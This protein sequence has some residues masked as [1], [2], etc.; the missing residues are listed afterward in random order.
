M[1]SFF[2]QTLINACA[3]KGSQAGTITSF[4]PENGREY[5]GREYKTRFSIMTENIIA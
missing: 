4:A 3:P 2:A 5:H 1:Q